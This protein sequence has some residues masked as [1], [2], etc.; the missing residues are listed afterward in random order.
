MML[1]KARNEDQ[2]W[3]LDA[4]TQNKSQSPLA[5]TRAIKESLHA[6][7]L[8][9]LPT[10]NSLLTDVVDGSVE[11]LTFNRSSL[12][13][14]R[15]QIEASAFLAVEHLNSHSDQV[16]PDLP[17]LLRPCDVQFTLEMRNTQFSPIEAVRQ[18]FITLQEN[19]TSLVNQ[20]PTAI[21]GA[22]RSAASEVVSVLGGVYE[23]PEISSSSTSGALDNKD[24]APYF[25]RTIPTNAGDAKAI[26]AYFGMLKVSNFAVLYVNDDYGNYYA[27]ALSDDA[28]ASGVQIQL[29]SFEDSVESSI[30]ASIVQLHQTG[31]RYFVGVFDAKTWRQV[32]RIAYRGGVMGQPGYTW[33]LSD[34]AL[35]I[36]QPGFHLS[37]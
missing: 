9:L 12:I 24:A 10:T 4:G 17:N 31:L 29:V 14:Y 5:V 3:K 18:L 1:G 35:E 26:I 36:T 19:H 27:Q 30:E 11:I 8:S 16:L 2:Q 34:S 33:L 6:H 25:S 32:V 28:T 13:D 22:A 23:I 21:I 15:V 37:R 7:F 20:M